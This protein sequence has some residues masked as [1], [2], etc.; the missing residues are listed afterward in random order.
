MCVNTCE[1]EGSGWM[2]PLENLSIRGSQVASEAIYGLMYAR[3]ICGA[4]A[5]KSGRVTAWKAVEAAG[6]RGSGR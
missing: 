2:L 6:L 3:R 5:V 1:V 4:T